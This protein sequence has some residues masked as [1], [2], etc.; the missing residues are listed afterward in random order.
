MNNIKGFSLKRFF[1][2]I[3]N[4][5]FLERSIILIS[6]AAI[7]GIVIL[8]SINSAMTSPDSSFYPTFYLVILYIGGLM[9]TEYVFKGL[10]DETKGAAWLVLPA[11]IFEKFTSQLVLTTAV[12]SAGVMTLFFLISLI[13]EGIM[14]LLIGS[15]HGLFNPFSEKILWDT[16]V[17]FIIQSIFLLGALYFKRSSTMKTILSLCIYF[18]IFIIVTGISVKILYSGFLKDFLLNLF[19]KNDAVTQIWSITKRATHIGFWYVFAPLCWVIGYIRLK[20]KEV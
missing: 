2:M 14:H 9:L 5:L 8:L 20:E 10:H 16:L 18:F 17:Y 1:L 7:G 3:R 6:S 4:T 12:F 15:G 13:S 11:S 19:N